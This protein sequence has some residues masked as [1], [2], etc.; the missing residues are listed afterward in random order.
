MTCI[1]Q[2]L[3]YNTGNAKGTTH[4]RKPLRGNGNTIVGAPH[5]KPH[6]GDG[7]TIVG[8]PHEKP[9]WGDGNTAVGE[10]HI[11]RVTHGKRDINIGTA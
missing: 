6:G 10:A 11:V 2:L 7:N 9:H 4:G 1:I 5:E 8:A 3:V